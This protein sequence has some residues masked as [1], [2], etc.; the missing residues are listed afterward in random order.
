MITQ[1]DRNS[2]IASEIYAQLERS[3]ALWRDRVKPSEDEKADY[4]TA[5]ER[6]RQAVD[7]VGKFLVEP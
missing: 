5:L 7:Y 3:V 6:L 4:Q 2:D 1:K